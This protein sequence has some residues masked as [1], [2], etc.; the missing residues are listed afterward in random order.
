MPNYQ[1]MIEDAFERRSEISPATVE[2]GLAQALD[3]ILQ[4]LNAGRLRVAEKIGG[5]WTTHQWVKKAV[6]LYFRTHDNRVM[7]GGG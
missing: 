5:A 4:E 6:L 1:T 7:P 3:H 2:P